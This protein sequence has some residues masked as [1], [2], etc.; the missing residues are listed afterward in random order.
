M[1]PAMTGLSLA[2]LRARLR[3]TLA[4]SSPRILA[5]FFLFGLLNNVL[6]VILLTAAHDLVG[7]SIP[8]ALVLLF[9]VLPAFLLKI[10]APYFIHLVPYAARIF[11][12]A[13][14]AA[15]G[16]LLVALTPA[17]T[18]GGTVAAKMAGVV[19]ASLA[20]GAGELSFLG[21]THW[22]GP[23]SLAAWGSGTGAA[24]LVGAGV[25][26]LATIT[27]GWSVRGTLL[28]SAALPAGMVA[29]F[30]AVLPARPAAK[31]L[32]ARPRTEREREEGEDEEEVD[33]DG[34]DVGLLSQGG[35]RTER[36]G[37][38][39]WLPTFRA[40]LRRARKL[41]IPLYVSPSILDTQYSPRHS[42]LPL[43]LVYVA[44]YTIN[45]GVAPTLLFPLASTP[46]AHFRAFYPTY[47]AIYQVG[48]FLSRSSTPFVRVHNLYLPSILQVANL[49]VL[50]A[51]A[52]LDFLPSV[53][54]IFAIVFWEGLLGGL[55]YV[56]AFAEILDTV[57]LDDREFSLSATSVSDSA[58]IC[59]ASFVG[60]ALEV[61]ICKNQVAHGRD[62]CTR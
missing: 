40:N 21:L 47:N 44:E 13:G 16:M 11:L 35:K 24:G 46:F 32:E 22:Y 18:D 51:H 3:D 19:L 45:Q 7:P 57:P 30:F 37:G 56:N 36:A 29:S 41:V 48:V 33:A 50:T 26:A 38:D 2:P 62:Y 17:Y 55:V 4:A 61:A 53:Y 60:M 49:V 52:I 15:T 28:A 34:A 54:V 5:A 23:G 10:V 58:G 12:I 39:A 31:A 6:Y 43:L 59:I 42:M 27:W 14:L 1:L 20:S 8:K 25:Y 9:D